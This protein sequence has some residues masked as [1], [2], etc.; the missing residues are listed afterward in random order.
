MRTRNPLDTAADVEDANQ[1]SASE[2]ISSVRDAAAAPR[3]DAA[4]ERSAAA[5]E[6]ARR[7]PA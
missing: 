3:C 5:Q 7:T 1:R 2:A 4:R 6:A